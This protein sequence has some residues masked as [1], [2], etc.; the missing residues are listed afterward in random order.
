MS[1]RKIINTEKYIIGYNESVFKPFSQRLWREKKLKKTKRT[2]VL[3][4]FF[5]KKLAKKVFGFLKFENFCSLDFRG[6]A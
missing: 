4:I 5:S 1:F 2:I 3:K 6:S